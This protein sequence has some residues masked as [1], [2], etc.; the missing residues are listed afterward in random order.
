M[1]KGPDGPTVGPLLAS[2]LQKARDYPDSGSKRQ[3]EPTVRESGPTV[4]TR[5]RMARTLLQQIATPRLRNCALLKQIEKNPIDAVFVRVHAEFA[6]IHAVVAKR[7]KWFPKPLI[8]VQFLMGVPL[9]GS[10]IKKLPKAFY[11]LEVVFRGG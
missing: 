2:R 6:H 7:L 3:Q 11:R 5:P 10:S 8:Q 9:T 4:A 1:P